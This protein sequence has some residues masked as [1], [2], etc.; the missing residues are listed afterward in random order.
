MAEYV[1]S[2]RSSVVLHVCCRSLDVALNQ[3]SWFVRAQTLTTPAHFP[4]IAFIIA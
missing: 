4:V 3:L 2:E 1:R